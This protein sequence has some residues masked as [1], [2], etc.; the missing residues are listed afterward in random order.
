MDRKMIY[1]RPADQWVNAL[2]LGNGRLG[3][4]IYGHTAV[5]RIQLNEDSL[6]SGKAM[7]RN[8]PHLKEALP[9]IRKCVFD[10]DI[11]QA[12]DL[13]QRYMVGAPT[14]MRHYESLG[15]LDIGVNR[16]SPFDGGWAPNS[17]GASA[18]RQELNLTSGLHTLAWEEGGVTYTR[19][20]FISHPDQVLC[21]RLT[22]SAAGKLTVSARID[23]CHIFEGMVPDPRRPGELIRAGGWGSMFL[24]ENH[25]LDARTLMVSGNASGVRFGLALGMDSDGVTDDPYT[26]LHTEGATTVCLYLA[27]ATDNREPDPVAVSLARVKAAQS[28][29]FD[30]L[31]QRHD[32]DFRA[33]MARCTLDLGPAVHLPVEERIARLAA[34]AHDP[35][36]AALY[37]TFGRYLMVSGG[38]ADSAALNLQGIW[39]REFAPMWDSKYTVN[40]NLQMNYWPAEVCNLSDAHHSLFSLIRSVCERGRET[41]RVMY[42]MRGSVCHHNTDF[43]GDCAPQDQYMAS[44]SWPMGGAWLA[45]HLWEHYLF[46]G[47]LAFLR[48]WQ[49]VMR[50]FALFFVDFLAEDG[51]G[52]M[53]TCPS[54]SP[55]NRYIL[56]DGYD[57]PICAGP[58][59]DNQLLRDLFGACAEAD[60]L[61]GL[62][63]GL[64]GEFRRLAALLPEDRIGSKGQLLEWQEE[65]PEK[66]PGMGHI[67]HLYGSFPSSQINWKDTPDLMRAVDKSIRLRVENG[68]D[69][70]AWPLAWRGCQYARLLDGDRV[71][72]AAEQMIAQA[73]DSF[74][75]GKE[76]FQIDGNF[77]M[78]AA[79]AEALV[80]S[81]V[82]LI[83]LLPALPPIWPEGHARGLMARGGVQVDI[84]WA[85]GQLTRAEL[86]P[87]RDGEIRLRLPCEVS[88]HADGQP[89]ACE[90]G[91]YGPCLR[92]RAGEVYT[93]LPVRR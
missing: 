26:Q 79:I 8:N 23:R 16:L 62:T 1:H 71:G 85:E 89:V 11:R 45:M 37:F 80:Q 5:D 44:T 65:L 21:M 76:I 15:E 2:P 86:R 72:R 59:M 63:D 58:A 91:E 43:Y 25:T 66:M 12:E 55:E 56:P 78:T 82:G 50:E 19:Q 31:L 20:T 77:G 14:S 93:L 3:A 10:G 52:R 90:R 54:L 13:I 53:V 7:N 27:A 9:R 57:S 46:T 22:A 41:A 69:P 88:V 49:P 81:H 30:A 70:G 75:N 74:L 84:D 38:R 51:K 35:D 4:M 40:I 42:G 48:E 18:Y 92:A 17:D 73:T 34:G 39:C 60:R 6:W 67:S 47:D 24:D 61:L 33:Q 36:L 68:A 29:G 83:H 32:A 28:L 87:A 64:T